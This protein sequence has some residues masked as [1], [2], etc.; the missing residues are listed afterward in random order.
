MPLYIQIPKPKKKW[1]MKMPGSIFKSKFTYLFYIDLEEKSL[2]G[3]KSYDPN[4]LGEGYEF[5]E[6]EMNLNNYTRL[7]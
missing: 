7:L 3:K 1:F 4:S 2:W 6:E 5:N